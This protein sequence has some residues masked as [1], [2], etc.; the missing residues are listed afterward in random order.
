MS[1]SKAVKER[2]KTLIAEVP[3]LSRSG[4]GYQQRAWL[5]AA[6]S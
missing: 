5:T 3:E 6:P 2:I 4:D 1:D